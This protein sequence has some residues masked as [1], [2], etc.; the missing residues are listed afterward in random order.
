MASIQNGDFLEEHV[1]EIAM[2]TITTAIEKSD[3]RL[4][5]EARTL[6]RTGC[7]VRVIGKKNDFCS[8]SIG[9][10]RLCLSIGKASTSGYSGDDGGS[11]QSR[12][13]EGNWI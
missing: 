3:A 5:K 8:H 1:A 11:C 4:F 13:N 7:E 12:S 10:H 2:V 6:Q 9:S